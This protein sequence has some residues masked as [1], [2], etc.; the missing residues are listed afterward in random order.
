MRALRSAGVYAVSVVVLLAVLMAPA[1]ATAQ[2]ITI[3]DFSTNQSALTLTYPPA[4]TSASSS[5]SGAGRLEP[6]TGS[7]AARPGSGGRS[8]AEGPF[9]RLP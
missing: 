4:G 2:S 8:C 6:V 1:A 9:F 3:D 7:R 5:V